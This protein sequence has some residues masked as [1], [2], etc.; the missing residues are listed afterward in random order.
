MYSDPK[1]EVAIAVVP[2][3]IAA[4][5][6]AAAIHGVQGTQDAINSSNSNGGPMAA[7]DPLNADNNKARRKKIDSLQDRI[8]EHV[9]K[10]QGDPNC[11][12]VC[13]WEKEIKAWKDRIDRLKKRLP[14]CE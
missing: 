8:D 13:H 6:I 3:A 11:D 4:V 5:A 14:G 12:A 2:I 9:K 1:G 7:P 10:I